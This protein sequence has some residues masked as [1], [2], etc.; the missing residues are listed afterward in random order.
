MTEAARSPSMVGSVLQDA[1]QVTRLIGRGGMGAVYEATQTRLNKRVAIKVMDRTLA[2]NPEALARFRREI[3]VTAKLAH[4]NIIQV[5]DFGTAPTGEPYLVMEYLEGEDL[6]QRLARVTRL[7]L[8]RAVPIVKQLASAL[9]VTHAEGIVHRDLKP[10]NVFLVSVPGQT[11]FVKVVDFGISKVLKA[12]TTKLTKAQMVVGTPE[13]MSPE[14]A[15]GKVDEIDHRSDQWSVACIAWHMLVGQQP[16]FGPDVNTILHQVMNGEP[17]PLPRKM[18]GLLP[19]EVEA[20]LRR[21]L[22]KRQQDRF[23]TITALSRALEAAAPL[24]GTTPAPALRR[25]TPEK[26]S[27]LFVGQDVPRASPPSTINRPRPLRWVLYVA[28]AAVAGIGVAWFTKAGQSP[29]A[30]PGAAPRGEPTVVPVRAAKAGAAKAVDPRR[31]R[32]PPEK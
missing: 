2:A 27:S 20:V 24:P 7:P 9:A 13:Y 5:S 3:Q 12:S 26:R 10:A 15:A 25:V 31:R 18:A 28:L 8:E 30:A 21:A 14:Q 29:A 6:D 22:S 11:D 17:P 4:P 16:F 32:P 1:Y 19:K 23:P